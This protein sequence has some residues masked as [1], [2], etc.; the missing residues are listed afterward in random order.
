MAPAFGNGKKTGDKEEEMGRDE[1]N[2]AEKEE[3]RRDRRLYLFMNSVNQLG[4]GDKQ[5]QKKKVCREKRVC[6]KVRESLTNMGG[7]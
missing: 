5:S 4:P 1:I 6:I 7:T 2:R 3:G